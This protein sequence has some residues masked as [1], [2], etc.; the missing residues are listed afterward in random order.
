M[1]VSRSVVCL[2]L[3][4]PNIELWNLSGWMLHYTTL[5]QLADPLQDQLSQLGRVNFSEGFA[6][7]LTD[8]Q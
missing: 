6:F 7:D 5:Q 2:L 8:F 4:S 3:T 1:P